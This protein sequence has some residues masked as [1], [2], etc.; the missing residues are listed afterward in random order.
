MTA[1]ETP[2]RTRAKVPWHFWLL[3]GALVIY[4]G[5]R[6]VQGLAWFVG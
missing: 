4:L 2:A 5:W 3:L 6:A 1:T